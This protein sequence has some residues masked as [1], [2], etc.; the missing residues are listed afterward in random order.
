MKKRALA[1]VK[2]QGWLNSWW[3]CVSVHRKHLAPDGSPILQC[4]WTI[5]DIH[6]MNV[7]STTVISRVM[8]IFLL[9]IGVKS[10]YAQPLGLV[11]EKELLSRN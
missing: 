1:S 7:K 6:L 8:S 2:F 4:F 10:A 9:H 3:F 5:S 11:K